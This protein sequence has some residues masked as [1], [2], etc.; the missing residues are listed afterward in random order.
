MAVG[1]K[2]LKVLLLGVRSVAVDVMDLHRDSAS[3]RVELFPAA[4]IAFV[5]SLVQDVVAYGLRELELR[6]ARAVVATGFPIL[7]L[8]R[9]L[10]VVLTLR[11]AID[12]RPRGIS[13]PW[14]NLFPTT[15][16][17]FHALAALRTVNPYLRL[18]TNV[19]LAPLSS[20]EPP[21]FILEAANSSM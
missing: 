7:N 4:P 16:A 13:P 1:A 18:M 8:L 2:H 9:V 5:A 19:P 12:D 10:P 6:S 17:R 20:S 14:P 15:L 21:V 3:R 11:R